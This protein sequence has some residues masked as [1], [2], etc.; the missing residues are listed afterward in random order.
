M[1]KWVTVLLGCALL[2]VMASLFWVLS[3]N[4]NDQY[5]AGSGYAGSIKDS[6]GKTITTF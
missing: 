6:S 2:F 1:N 5:N 3:A 4:A